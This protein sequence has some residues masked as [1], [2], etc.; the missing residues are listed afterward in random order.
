LEKLVVCGNKDK[1]LC[2]GVHKL[3]CPDCGETHFGQTGRSLSKRFTVKG[4]HFSFR[5]NNTTLKYVNLLE[6]S[7]PDQACNGIALP[8]PL[9]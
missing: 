4:H 9:L 8:L 7:G 3:I 6:P 5:N 1:C 2:N